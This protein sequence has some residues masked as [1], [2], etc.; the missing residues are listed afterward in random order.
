MIVNEDYLDAAEDTKITWAQKI[1][2]LKFIQTNL[3]ICPQLD[4]RKPQ[5][6][7]KVIKAKPNNW[8]NHARRFLETQ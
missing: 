8:Q 3:S 7:A 4:L 6:I 5:H 2:L 1:E